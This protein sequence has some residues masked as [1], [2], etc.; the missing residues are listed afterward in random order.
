MGQK[1]YWV[2][3]NTECLCRNFL[4]LSQINFSKILEKVEKIEMG[5]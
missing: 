5:W 1:P 3:E 4:V 2:G